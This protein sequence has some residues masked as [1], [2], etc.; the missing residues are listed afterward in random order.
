MFQKYK[1]SPIAIYGLGAE[2]EKALPE[3]EKDF[4]VIGLLDGYRESG[5]MYNKPIISMQQAMESHISLILVVARPG[6][7]KA[8]SKR[9]GSLCKEN[10]IDLFDVRGRDLGAEKKLTYHFGRTDGITKSRMQQLIIGKGAIS[11]DL[12]DTLVMR[13]T[14]FPEDIFEIVDYQ[15]REKGIIIE[16]FCKKRLAGE[17]YLSKYSAPTLTDIYE[18]MKKTYNIPDMTPHELA[19]LEWMADARMLIPRQEMCALI[20]EA[21]RQGKEVY[22]VSDTYYSKKQIIK[23]LEKCNITFYTDIFASCEYRTGKTQQLFECLKEKIHGRQCI[24]I[25]DDAVADIESAKKHGL[26]ACQVYS[27]TELLEMTGYLGLWNRAE[28]LAD[29]I[30][31]GMFTARLFNSPFQF[32]AKERKISVKN[33]NDI[34][35]LFFAPIISDFVIWFKKQIKEHGLHNVWFCARDGYLIKK[36][37]DELDNDRKS[38]YFLTS[39]TA[40]IRAGMEDEEDIRYVANMK[41]SGTLREQLEERFGITVPEGSIREDNG[42]D[43]LDYLQEILSKAS[44]NRENYKKYI[45]GLPVEE[46][47]VA[48]FDFVAKGTSQMYIERFAGRHLKGLYFLQLE[49]RDMRGKGLDIQSFYRE[50]EQ[51]GSV[52]FENYYILEAMLTAPLPSVTGFDEKGAPHYAEETRKKE[53]IEC[54]LAAQNGIIDYFKTYLKLCPETEINGN[55]ELD[56]I[57]LGLIHNIAILDRRFLSLKVEDPFFHRNTDMT[58]LI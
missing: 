56:E 23:M 39:R 8:I 50:G 20:E 2:T 30:K 15:L 55:R 47:T 54:F 19:E 24:H 16:D 17:K 45:D 29:R 32:E 3:L 26:A 35:Y 48:F 22:I 1:N 10:Q 51:E 5:M 41:F 52:V 12:F 38:V 36:L 13:Q 11:V 58:D 53:D 49:E 43:L 25:G 33:A 21:F 46:G 18:Y 4:Q 28:S 40:A 37:Y 57:F 42:D 31:T 27:G 34:G 44:V 14:L 7:C 9:I 6:S